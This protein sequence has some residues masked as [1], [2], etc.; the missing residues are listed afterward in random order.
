ML[1]GGR[2]N[3]PGKPVIYGAITYAGAMLEVL[4]HARIGKLPMSHLSIVAEVPA[5]V[6]I[7]IMTLQAM[8]PGWDAQESRVARAIGDLWLREQRS[9]ILLVPSIVTRD[10]GNVLVNPMHPDASKIHLSA[11]QAVA[12]DQRLFP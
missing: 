3:S 12:W 7:E 4:V 2:W 8:E 9:A 10:D 5:G 11:P 1:V 6:S